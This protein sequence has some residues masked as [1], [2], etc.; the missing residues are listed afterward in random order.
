MKK[1]FLLLL[2]IPILGFS[3]AE[4][5]KKEEPTLTEKLTVSSIQLDPKTQIYKVSSLEKASSLKAELSYG[6]CLS[7]SMKSKKMVE[8]RFKAFSQKVLSCK[9]LP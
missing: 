9:I 4:A 8:V 2:L 7:E 6:K 3:Q 1:S 5:Q